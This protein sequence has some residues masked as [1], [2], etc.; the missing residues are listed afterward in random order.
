VGAPRD[1]PTTIEPFGPIV[2][3]CISNSHRSM[4]NGGGD[5]MF[6][7]GAVANNMGLS[8]CDIPHW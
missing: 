5:A 8:V 6:R 4:Y 3:Q 7:H 2:A 1:A